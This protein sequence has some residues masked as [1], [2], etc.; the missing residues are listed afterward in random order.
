MEKLQKLTFMLGEMKLYLFQGQQS[1]HVYELGI[2][3]SKPLRK[4]ES[5]LYNIY[6]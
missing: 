3:A 1:E 6:I 5:M 4:E 2:Y